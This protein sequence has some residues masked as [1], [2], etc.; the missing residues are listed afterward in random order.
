MAVRA[1]IIGNISR[2][3]SSRPDAEL[4][5]GLRRSGVE[6][7]AAIPAGSY[8]ADIFKKDGIKVIPLDIRHKISPEAII[9]IRRLIIK[10]KYDIIHLLNTKAIVNGTIA[11]ACKS[12]KIIAYRGAAGIY[13][14]DP[15]AWLSH[16]NPRID[17]VICNSEYVLRHMRKQLLRNPGKAYLIYKGMDISW[18]E[19]IQPLL[20]ESL[21]IPEN[22]ILVGC[23]ANFRK[24]KGVAYLL[25]ATRYLDPSMPVHFLLAGKGME[26]AGAGSLVA[27]EFR[28]RVHFTGFRSDIYEVI[29]A[30][31]IYVQPSLSESLSRSVMEAMCI[32]IPC[33]V[34]NA[35]GLVELSD[36]GKCAGLVEKGNAR[37]LADAI[38]KMAADKALR[39]NYIIL[40]RKRMAEVFSVSEM[41]R[42]TKNL[43]EKLVS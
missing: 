16:L 28:D 2:S 10:E 1:L 18:F 13:W 7:D 8:Y 17:A 27:P 32:G 34:S 25:E 9:T 38:E 43:Y 35:G 31:D 30:C 14:Y 42:N 19:G 41:I 24:V 37:A 22:S 36:N 5:T 29:S 15:T 20:R 3:A 4:V 11:A 21:G 6:I 26:E 23:V 40:A 33:I 39:D 12:V